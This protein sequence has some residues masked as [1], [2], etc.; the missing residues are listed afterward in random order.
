VQDDRLGWIEPLQDDV[1]EE[2]REHEPESRS[3]LGPF[4]LERNDGAASVIAG[5]NAVLRRQVGGEAA[6]IASIHLHG[7]PSPRTPH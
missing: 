1:V 7:A 2:D 5:R 6:K 4:G 3:I